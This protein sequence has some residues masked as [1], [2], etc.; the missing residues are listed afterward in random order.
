M[1]DIR[2]EVHSIK[3]NKDLRKISELKSK[4]LNKRNIY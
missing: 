4:D 1:K 2:R 3:K